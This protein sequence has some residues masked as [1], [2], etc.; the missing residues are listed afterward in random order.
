[1]CAEYPKLRKL[2]LRDRKKFGTLIIALQEKTGNTN[3]TEMVPSTD[4]HE[5]LEEDTVDK[6]SKIAELAFNMLNT[7]LEYLD[8]EMTTW[9]IDILEDVNSVEEY[10]E[11][12][13]DIE[14]YVVEEL[15]KAKEF[16]GFFAR[17]SLSLLSL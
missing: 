16:T 4:K 2:K 12:P 9:F 17:G 6:A 14:M 13:F 11:L 10:E 3:L 15:L 8:S 1:M 7:L 5:D